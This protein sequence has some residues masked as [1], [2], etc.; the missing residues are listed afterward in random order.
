MPQTDLSFC[1]F[2]I[3][4]VPTYSPPESLLHKEYE[5]ASDLKESAVASGSLNYAK[6]TSATSPITS[7]VGIEYL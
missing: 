3:P 5:T 1:L 7:D 4:I 6:I 2:S